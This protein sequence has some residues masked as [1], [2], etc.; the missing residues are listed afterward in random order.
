MSRRSWYSGVVLSLVVAAA[1]VLT[2]G[3]SA[4]AGP[5]VPL[6]TLTPLP[7]L[8]LPPLPTPPL[9]TPPLPTLTL[10]PSAPPGTKPTTNPPGP[11]P[12]TAPVPPAGGAFAPHG[13]AAGTP[14]VGTMPSPDE[15]A[16]MIADNP[17]A[18]L[19][20]Q[21]AVPP[22][23]TPGAQ[24][25]ARLDDVEHR[26]EYLHNV[27]T[28]TT[29]DLAV[30]QRAL[31]PLPQLLTALTAPA[32]PAPATAP[33]SDTPAG[34]VAALS[35]A[36]ASGQAELARQQTVSQLLQQQLTSRMLAAPV[37]VPATPSGWTGGKLLRPVAGPITSR[38][39]NRLDPYYHVW[40]L[41]PGIDIAAAPGTPIYAAAAGRVTRAGWYGGYGN[42]TCIEHGQFDGQ[43]LSTCYGHQSTLLATPGQQVAAGQVLGLV[44]STGAST[45]PHL[46]FEVRLD[47]RPVD[48]LPWLG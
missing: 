43:R 25:I 16:R 33:A 8:P 20:P 10:P 45:G 27:L 15:V 37:A 13:P 26:I 24:L 12:T 5:G 31:G 47:G 42:Y 14:D 4:Q 9:P 36:I 44:G 41:H 29:A 30:A 7:T 2:S 38:F 35:G 23:I 1:V 22:A 28:R 3:P 40:Q 48:P 17:G 39:G 18:D 6:P 32:S 11:P 19:Y 46:H 34:R 21:P